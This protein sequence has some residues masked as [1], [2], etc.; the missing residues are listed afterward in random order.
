MNC[1]SVCAQECRDSC[2]PGLLSRSLDS[3]TENPER[4]FSPCLQ[5]RRHLCL[6]EQLYTKC[7]RF[8]IEHR[9]RLARLETCP[10]LRSRCVPSIRRRADNIRENSHRSI[11][12][13]RD[14]NPQQLQFFSIQ[15]SLTDA[16][17]PLDRLIKMCAARISFDQLEI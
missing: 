7:N 1:L 13:R 9:R 15:I 12:R 6:A 16:E 2:A 17:L 4:P 11:Q 10:P 14:R 8:D 3:G 5:R